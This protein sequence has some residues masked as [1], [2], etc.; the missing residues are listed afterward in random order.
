M[1]TLDSQSLTNTTKSN[2][3]H[4]RSSFTNYLSP[5][6]LEKFYNTAAM[7][8]LFSDCTSA[9]LFMLLGLAACIT[10]ATSAPTAHRVHVRQATSDVNKLSEVVHYS[11]SDC[12]PCFCS[13]PMVNTENIYS[14]SLGICQMVACFYI[15]LLCSYR[16]VF[17]S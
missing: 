6:T 16:F 7:A 9:I 12:R 3:S 10:L 17:T 5:V 8:R 14:F 4:S 13:L 2:W 11:V 1:S 15:V